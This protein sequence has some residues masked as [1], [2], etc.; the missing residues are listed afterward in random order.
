EKLEAPELD[1]KPEKLEA[2]EKDE[3]PEAP[4]PP[5]IFLSGPGK[6]VVHP[7]IAVTPNAPEPPQAP[8]QPIINLQDCINKKGFCITVADNFGESIVIVKDKDNK[9]VQAIFLNDWYKDKQYEEKYGEIPPVRK[10][11]TIRVVQGHP[12]PLTSLKEGK[13]GDP[14]PDAVL[15]TRGSAKPKIVLSASGVAVPK[16]TGSINAQ[17]GEVVVPRLKVEE[18]VQPLAVTKVDEVVVVGIKQE[19]KK[20]LSAKVATEARPRVTIKLDKPKDAEP[21]KPAPAQPKQ[22][23]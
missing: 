2:P 6:V 18:K 14:K 19:A 1:E 15:V 8:D 22:E 9:I 17:A 16:A 20:A 4:E 7:R 3:I 11:N 10:R 13:D 5:N 21:A 12:Y 23:Q